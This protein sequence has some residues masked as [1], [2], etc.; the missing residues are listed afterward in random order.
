MQET[1][2]IESSIG[3]IGGITG[4][5]SILATAYAFGVRMSAI[6]VKVDLLWK[7][8]VEDSLRNQ[9]G[10]GN[11]ARGSDWKLT[12]KFLVESKSVADKKLLERI[13]EWVRLKSPLPTNDGDLAIKLALFLQW[14]T[15]VERSEKFK[16]TVQEYLALL[17]ARVR[18]MEK[19]PC[20]AN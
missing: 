4:I 5:I 12:E 14:P 9:R 10:M 3:L 20:M 8:L 16:V 18:G 13:E 17:T 19:K 7:M 2:P 11:D 15:L 6:N 1:V